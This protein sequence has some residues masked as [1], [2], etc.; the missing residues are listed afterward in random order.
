MSKNKTKQPQLDIGL[1]DFHLHRR[2][3]LV[4]GGGQ[5]RDTGVASTASL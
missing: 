2:E 5:L 3:Q 1:D 4:D